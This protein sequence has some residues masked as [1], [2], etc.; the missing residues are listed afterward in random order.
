[1][2]SSTAALSPARPV[3]SKP[4]TVTMVD[5]TKLAAILRRAEQE[6]EKADT[7]LSVAY[8]PRARVAEREAA[9]L[10]HR[11][12]CRSIIGGMAR[13]IAGGATRGDFEDGDVLISS[14]RLQDLETRA[15]RL[16]G[17]VDRIRGAATY[18]GAHARMKARA[19]R[20]TVRRCA[21]RLVA[22]LAG[23]REETRANLGDDPSASLALEVI[24]EVINRAQD[25]IRAVLEVEDARLAE[26]PD[27]NFLREL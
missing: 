27:W 26:G 12:S 5:C 23:C 17:D 18:A 8:K 24:T 13:A 16:E 3:A 20:T 14:A 1:M 6:L 19:M 25:R 11:L 15:M 10:A 2:S 7:R 21:G 4:V 9:L 22:V